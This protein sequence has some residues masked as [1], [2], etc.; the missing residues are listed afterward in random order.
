MD[1]P[2]RSLLFLW[3]KRRH[4]DFVKSEPVGCVSPHLHIAAPPEGV[5]SAAC[6]ALYKETG[7]LGRLRDGM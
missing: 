3:G 1:H 4:A 6:L 7:F 5:R 2:N